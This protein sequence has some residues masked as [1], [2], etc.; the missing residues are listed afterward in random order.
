[1]NA[2]LTEETRIGLKKNAGFAAKVIVAVVENIE[3][4]EP[5]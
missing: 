1:M 2:G 4:S 3:P 5:I